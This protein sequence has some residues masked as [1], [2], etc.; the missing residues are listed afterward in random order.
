MKDLFDTAEKVEL[1]I[2]A[3]RG[4]L[5]DPGWKL[6]EQILDANIEILRERLENGVE[7]ETKEDID[8]IRKQLAIFRQTRNMPNIMIEK[9]TNADADEPNDDP[10]L[11]V[12]ELKKKRNT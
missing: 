12:E 10:F 1:G 11:S 7:E 2:A 9:L 4:L 6:L 8:V 5:N 3:F